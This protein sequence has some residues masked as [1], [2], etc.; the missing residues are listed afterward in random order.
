[1]ARVGGQS[2]KY[3]VIIFDWDGT[4]VDSTGRIVDSMQMA[5]DTVG[6]P[7]LSNSDIKHIIGLGL[8]EA[9]K[10]LWPDIIDDQLQKM[11]SLYAD[12]FSNHSHVPTDF[13]PQARRL[14]E[15]LNVLGYDLAVATGKT[16][17]GLDEMLDRMDVKDIFTITRCA[18]ETISKPDP[19]MLNEILKELNLTSGQALMVGDTSYDLDMAKSIG[20]DAIG[21]TYGA[22]GHEILQASGAKALCHNLLEFLNWIKKNG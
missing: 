20:M 5:A 17:R 9:I 15:E 3:R 7:K 8:P 16:R 4:L 21:M 2:K 14:F 6:L 19:L 22:H 1:M 11:R 13:Y 12:N 10:L 18:D